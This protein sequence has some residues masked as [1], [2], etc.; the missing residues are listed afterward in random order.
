MSV[1]PSSEPTTAVEPRDA[2]SV[3]IAR[4]GDNGLELY[5][6]RRHARMAFAP[7]V[8]VFPGG[9]VD[10]QDYLD[11]S[12]STNPTDGGD[13]TARLGVDADRAAAIVRAACRELLEETGL[14]VEARD[15]N[16]WACWVT[17]TGSSRRFR[18]WFFLTSLPAGQ[19]PRDV[20]GEADTVMW[21]TPRETLAAGERQELDLWPPQHATCLELCE[22]G[23][24]GGA[25]GVAQ[26]RALAAVWPPARFTTDEEHVADVR[27]H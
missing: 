19:E 17:P 7:G 14:V 15:L 10:P 6:L 3:I 16:A 24:V 4:D 13:W 1:E 18:T 26:S 21:L 11:D 12:E 2:A 27:L 5:F 22:V 8:A 25:I 20:S 9:A 23:S